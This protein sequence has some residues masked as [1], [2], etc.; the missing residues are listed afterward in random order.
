[1]EDV[2][3]DSKFVASRNFLKAS[4]SLSRNHYTYSSH[5]LF[6]FFVN[7]NILFSS[8]NLLNVLDNY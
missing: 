7:L 2:S 5:Y 8:T 3:L 4:Q 6:R 1:M